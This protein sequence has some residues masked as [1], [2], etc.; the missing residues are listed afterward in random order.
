MPTRVLPDANVLHARTLRDW[1]LLLKDTGNAS[2]FHVFYTEDIL[3]ETIQSIRRRNSGLSGT[4]ITKV[5]DAIAGTMDG[6]ID[7]YPSG[8]EAVA[9]TD[10]F[11]R[12]IHAAAVAGSMDC[13]VSLDRGF[14]DLPTSVRDT[15]DYEIYTPD[16]FFVLIDDSSPRLVR[17]TLRRQIQ[18]F[19]G[20]GRTHL[21]F[22]GALAKSGCPA[23]AERI[24][25]RCREI[26]FD[27]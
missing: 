1:L 24:A 5:R 15:L 27:S 13:V 19:S 18:Y 9:L 8:Q 3:A 21:D 23:F 25:R 11:D 22:A 10:P 14:T 6:R 7:D 16:E 4:E 2:M 12:H 26:A 20:R 17:A